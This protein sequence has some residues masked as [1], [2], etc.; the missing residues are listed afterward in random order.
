MVGKVLINVLN[1]N[2]HQYLERCVDSVRCQTY[3]NIDLR[4]TDNASSEESRDYIRKHLGSVSVRFN[5]RNLGYANAHNAAMAEG[6]FDFY[7]PLNPDIEL[8]PD[9]VLQL[10][11][12]IE[13]APD[14]GSANGKVYF[15][16]RHGHRTNYLYSAGH[17]F[18]RARRAS[19][20][21]Y[22]Q[23]DT[24]AFA[25]PAFVFGANGAAPLYK[26]TF[27]EAVKVNGTY[28]DKD[29]FMYWEDTD[30]GWRGVLMGYRCLYVPSAVAHHYGFGSQGLSSRYVQYQYEKNRF[31][32]VYKNDLPTFLLA[33]LHVILFHELFNLCF[34]LYSSP[35]RV[36]QYLRGIAGFILALPRKRHERREIM[37]RRKIDKP[38]LRTLY[39]HP[40]LRNLIRRRLHF[41]ALANGAQ[42]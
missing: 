11:R 7:M 36:V 25:E 12:G 22:K 10:V 28:F 15:L 4:V 30:I 5:D 35:G 39:L 6:T 8:E 33:D 16:T 23:L 17:E 3:P 31:I 14:I 37:S 29:F 42:G 26:K 27:L 20:R 41:K 19:N 40:W 9:F 2:S 34:Y 38:T 32:T 13:S 24:G 18:D 1:Y 21:G